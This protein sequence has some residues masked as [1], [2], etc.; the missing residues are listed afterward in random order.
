M[1]EESEN[2]VM[3]DGASNRLSGRRGKALDASKVGSAKDNA[4]LRD[5]GA[6]HQAEGPKGRLPPA[7]PPQFI[8]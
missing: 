6:G 1:R 8:R 7:G 5:E 2:P 4:S 3:Q